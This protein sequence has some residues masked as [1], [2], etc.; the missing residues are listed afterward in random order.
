M[1][2]A[3]ADIRMLSDFITNTLSRSLSDLKLIVVTHMHP[4]HAGA[5]ERL[6]IIS[7]CKIATANVSGHWYKGFDGI[8]MHITDILLAKWVAKRM[9]KPAKLVW[10]NRK[11]KADILL[12]DEQT[13]PGF[14]EWQ[15][16]YTQGHTD[17]DISL[18][19][20]TNQ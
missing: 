10:Y 19:H 11:L 7:G 14:D 18:K 1:V 3:G 8:L 6:R 17:R 4:D 15:V 13:L 9:G 16:I 12:E 5:A 2:A 20:F